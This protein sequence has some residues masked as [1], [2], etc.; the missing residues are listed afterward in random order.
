MVVIVLC[1]LLWE[2]TTKHMHWVSEASVSHGR[3]LRCSGVGRKPQ[4]LI[5]LQFMQ[6]TQAGHTSVCVF[7]ASQIH[8]WTLNYC[9]KE[10]ALQ[11]VV[12]LTPRPNLHMP[13]DRGD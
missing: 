5:L 6:V 9:L 11:A 10:E 4:R 3:Q 1:V 2:A 7:I 13:T 8:S 12:H